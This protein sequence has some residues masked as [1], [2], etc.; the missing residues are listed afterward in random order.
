MWIELWSDHRMKIMEILYNVGRKSMYEGQWILKS[1]RK[2]KIMLKSFE[3]T[4]ANIW[5]ITTTNL[6]VETYN[7]MQY[8]R[9]VIL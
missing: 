3:R 5:C 1:L 4:I 6:E 2:I 7:N 9:M 8:Q